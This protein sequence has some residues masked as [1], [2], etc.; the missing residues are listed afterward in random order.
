MLFFKLLPNRMFVFKGDLCTGGK[1]AKEKI[2]IA[3][4]V[5]ILGIEKLPLLVVQKSAKPRCFKGAQLPSGVVYRNVMKVWMT[6]KLFEEYMHLIDRR[7]AARERNVVIILDNA[8]AHVQPR[9]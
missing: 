3:F 1:H 9:L 5:N 8:S 6:G 4:G 7:F 2:S